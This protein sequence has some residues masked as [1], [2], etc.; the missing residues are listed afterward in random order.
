M[1]MNSKNIENYLS[2]L[3]IRQKAGQRDVNII[4]GISLVLFIVSFAF[5]MLDRLSGRSLY[6]V[7]AI[8][9]VFGFS[10]LMV[11]VKLQITNASIEVIENLTR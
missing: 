1:I 6:I 11:W 10:S 8:L 5:G 4:A 7:G 2:I 3:K 9:I